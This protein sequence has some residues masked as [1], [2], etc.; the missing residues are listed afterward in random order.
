MLSSTVTISDSDSA[1]LNKGKRDKVKYVYVV[2]D[3]FGRFRIISFVY[4]FAY[5]WVFSLPPLRSYFLGSS[6]F[7]LPT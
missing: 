1:S 3:W 2:G 5:L 7:S 6:L 4:S